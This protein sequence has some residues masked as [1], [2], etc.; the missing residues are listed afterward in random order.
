MGDYPYPTDEFDDLEP[1]AGPRGAH[2]SRRSRW[3]TAW[4]FLL[5]IVLFPALAYGAVSYWSSDRGGAPA[6]SAPAAPAAAAGTPAPSTTASSGPSGAAS[7]TQTPDQ[8]PD[9]TAPATVADRGTRIVVFNATPRGGLAAD[10]AKALTTAGWTSVTPKN[11][12]GPMLG[13][14]TVLYGAA[15]HA[16]TARAAAKALGITTVKLVQNRAVDGL[17]VVLE[18]DYRP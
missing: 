17:E 12:T 2:R 4:P 8:T 10:A 13:S 11:Y 15:D 18:A 7:P 5:V 6:G 3:R 16:D 9:P 14:S 1:A